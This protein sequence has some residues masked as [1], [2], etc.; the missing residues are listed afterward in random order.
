M[1][2]ITSS[3]ENLVAS[4]VGIFQSLLSS[5]LAVGQSILAVGAT[6]VTSVLELAKSL[7]QFLLSTWLLFPS[8]PLLSFCLPLPL[9]FLDA[10]S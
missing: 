2:G 5:M 4:I 8:R 1:T 3:L 9:L 7:V 10:R 6:F